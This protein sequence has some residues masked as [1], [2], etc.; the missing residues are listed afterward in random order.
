MLQ[1]QPNLKDNYNKKYKKIKNLKIEQSESMK[2]PIEKDDRYKQI[3]KLI[4]KKKF[5]QARHAAKK[6]AGN[7]SEFLCEVSMLFKN[8]GQ[9]IS[10]RHLLKQALELDPKNSM[11]HY[12]YGLFLKNNK[13]LKDAEKE[14]KLAIRYDN[15]N[16]N[17]HCMLGNTLLEQNQTTAAETEF[18]QVLVNDKTNLFAWT[19]MAAVHM[20]NGELDEAERIYKKLIKLD[21]NYP[22]PY[23]NLIVLYKKL[24]R[25]SDLKKIFK[26]AEKAKIYITLKKE[27]S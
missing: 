3:A 1:L 13:E 7:D 21:K 18:T 9:G 22:V 2:K 6:L 25:D 8:L 17:A 16:V 15:S 23:I 26:L 14:F 19:G 12:T 10:A 11:V 27:N 24:H 4:A 5:S 20:K